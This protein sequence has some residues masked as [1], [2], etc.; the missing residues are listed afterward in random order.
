[1]VRRI[2]TLK[3]VECT[4]IPFFAL[5]WNGTSAL[6]FGDSLVQIV[7][8]EYCCHIPRLC[9]AMLSS[10]MDFSY[11]DIA[12]IVWASAFSLKEIFKKLTEVAVVCQSIVMI[13]TSR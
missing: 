7:K 4:F 11:C 1:M 10:A 13:S 5:A 2:G 12:I 9:M 3:F 6:D 8:W